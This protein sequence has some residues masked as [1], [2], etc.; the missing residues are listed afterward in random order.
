MQTITTFY[1][2]KQLAYKGNYFNGEVHGTLEGWYKSTEDIHGKQ[3]FKYNYLKGIP[4]GIHISWYASGKEQYKWYYINGNDISKNEY[5]QY[6]KSIEKAVLNI[7]NIG[8][9][10]LDLIIREYIIK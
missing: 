1:S 10:T 7:L 5:N 6:T 3:S 4:H 2:N 9:N 8:K